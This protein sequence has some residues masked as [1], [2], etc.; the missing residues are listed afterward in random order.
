MHPSKN[1]P[2]PTQSLVRSAFPKMR[3]S[4]PVPSATEATAASGLPGAAGGDNTLAEPSKPAREPAR[5]I[6]ADVVLQLGLFTDPQRKGIGVVFPAFDEGG[7]CSIII[8]LNRHSAL[9]SKPLQKLDVCLVKFLVALLIAEFALMRKGSEA[10]AVRTA[11]H[12]FV[13]VSLERNRFLSFSYLAGLLA[14]SDLLAPLSKLSIFGPL[15]ESATGPFEIGVL[16]DLE[17]LEPSLLWRRKED[18]S[19]V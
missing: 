17:L 18:P 15:N 10:A 6:Q 14:D 8:N 12:T 9:V 2:D 19:D 4:V 16:R 5:A 13:G 7:R 1:T 3:P 11:F